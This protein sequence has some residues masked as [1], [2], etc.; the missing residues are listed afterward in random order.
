MALLRPEPTPVRGT[1]AAG[2]AEV[3]ARTVEDPYGSADNPLTDEAL[4]AKFRGLADPVLGADTAAAVERAIWDMQDVAD[5]AALI[6]RLA[7]QGPHASSGS[8]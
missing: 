2:L 1:I 6:E 5:V 8:A 4:A 7:V 3:L